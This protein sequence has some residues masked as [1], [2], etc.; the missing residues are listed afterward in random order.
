[1]LNSYPLLLIG[2]PSFAAYIACRQVVA[3]CECAIPM[4]NCILRRIAQLTDGGIRPFAEL[5]I[6]LHSSHAVFVR[7]HE[8]SPASPRIRPHL[9]SAEVKFHSYADVDDMAN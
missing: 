1:M 4:L 7:I 8:L 6:E 3:T 2:I 9:R 5:D